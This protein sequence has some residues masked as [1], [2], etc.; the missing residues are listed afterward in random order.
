MPS[1]FYLVETITQVFGN[2]P[3]LVLSIVSRYQ[4]SGP[5]ARRSFCNM[6]GGRSSSEKMRREP[7]PEPPAAPPII[8]L[9]E[10]SSPCGS[11]PQEQDPDFAP[12]PHTSF[13][14]SYFP[15][16]RNNV[17]GGLTSVSDSLNPK[18][19]PEPHPAPPVIILSHHKRSASSSPPR[20]S[21]FASSRRRTSDGPE[22]DSPPETTFDTTNERYAM[23]SKA[24]KISPKGGKLQSSQEKKDK[25][26]MKEPTNYYT[27]RSKSMRRKAGKEAK[28]DGAGGVS[29]GSGGAG[30]A[31]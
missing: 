28:G 7:N 8:I 10:N 13:S 18:P 29:L 15:T 27:H 17:S 1:S 19:Q 31:V 25:E 3:H 21:S 9:A 14:R 16:P 11:P 4:T 6:T 23:G 2:A 12:H 30:G 5:V 20:A 26:E 22:L 24:S